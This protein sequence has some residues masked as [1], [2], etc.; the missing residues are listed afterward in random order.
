[1]KKEKNKKLEFK[2]TTKISYDKAYKNLFQNKRILLELLKNFVKEEFVKKIKEKDIKI[3]EK[4]FI[5][6][7]FGKREADMIY[8]I[9]LGKREVYIYIILEFQSEVDKTLPVRILSYICELYLSLLKESRRGKLPAVFSIVLYRGKKDWTIP[10][11]IKEMI[12]KNIPERY[13]PQYEYYPIIMK[14]IKEEQIAN[15][16]NIA[17]L[18][19]TLE[20]SGNRNELKKAI[21]KMVEYI[22]REKIIDIKDFI[23]WFKY[24]FKVQIREDEIKRVK[25]KKEVRTMLEYAIEDLKKEWLEEGINE[26]KQIGI[27]EGIIKGIIKGK[28]EDLIKQINK[29]YGITSKEAEQIRKCKE[30]KKLDKAIEKIIEADKKEEILKILN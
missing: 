9:R 8:R 24:V 19:I 28:Q 3:V 29:K 2:I 11:N 16:K 30:I 1:M 23:R 21:K 4:T 26:G 18:I 14:D 6:E 12:E 25:N 10:V 13:I 7:E 15:I 27:N 17:S 20:K 22:K 5:S